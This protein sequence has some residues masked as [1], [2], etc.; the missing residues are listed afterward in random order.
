MNVAGVL[1]QAAVEPNTEVMDV[2]LLDMDFWIISFVCIFLCI[3]DTVFFMMG[4]SPID[5]LSIQKITIKKLLRFCKI[6][7]FDE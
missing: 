3:L 5:L 6:E 1:G 7:A 4:G 2:F